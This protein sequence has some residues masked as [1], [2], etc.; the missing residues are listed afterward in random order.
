MFDNDAEWIDEGDD[1]RWETS[2]E[3]ECALKA[4]QLRMRIGDGA[5]CS[6]LPFVLPEP[7]APAAALSDQ[8]V[9]T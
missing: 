5:L 6:R 4:V 2:E 7:S 8:Q 1:W 3:R 9:A